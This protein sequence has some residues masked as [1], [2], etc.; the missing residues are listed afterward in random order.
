MKNKTLR[1][2]IAGAL[3]SDTK[4]YIAG[5]LIAGAVMGGIA[6]KNHKHDEKIRNIYSNLPSIKVT[7]N[8]GEGVDKLTGRYI[9]TDKYTVF[10]RRPQFEKDNPNFN[11][12]KGLEMSYYTIR[13][14]PNYTLFKKGKTLPQLLNGE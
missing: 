3:S 5:L 14:D 10:V 11:P 8:P 4:Q 6:Y 7:P 12:K 9:D 1:N 13:Y 2:I